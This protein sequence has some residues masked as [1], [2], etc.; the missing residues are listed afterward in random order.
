MPRSSRP[1]AYG[2]EYELFL[3]RAVTD[4]GFSLALPSN[5]HARA[6]RG[7]LYAYFKALR[8]DLSRPD[9]ITMCDSLSL[10]VEGCCVRAFPVADSWDNCLLRDALGIEKGA[11]VP[12]PP[13]LPAITVP[14]E[15]T[16]QEKLTAKLAEIRNRNKGAVK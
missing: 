8:K 14:V 15:P 13:A 10:A 2:T 4:G 3:R 9:L 1:A 7:K 11:A 16:A 6:F 5:S 12:P